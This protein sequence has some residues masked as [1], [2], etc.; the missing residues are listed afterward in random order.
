MLEVPV[1]AGAAVGKLVPIT[2]VCSELEDASHVKKV[3]DG[4]K[5]GEVHAA[6]EK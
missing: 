1:A 2:Q 4:E 3:V 5:T 6:S